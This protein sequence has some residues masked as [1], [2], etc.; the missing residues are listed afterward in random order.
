MKYTCM[1]LTCNHVCMTSKVRLGTS[2]QQ[3]SASKICRTPQDDVHA[4]WLNW[5]WVLQTW[6]DEV[7]VWARQIH[8]AAL[9]GWNCSHIQRAQISDSLHVSIRSRKH[10][11]HKLKY[12]KQCIFTLQGRCVIWGPSILSYASHR[13][14]LHWAQMCLLCA[15]DWNWH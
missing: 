6:T 9:R 8:Q 1:F 14:D 13:T 10:C 5:L 12:I 15:R 7:Q 2:G 3:A 4:L 11:N